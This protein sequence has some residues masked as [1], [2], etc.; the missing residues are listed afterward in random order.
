MVSGGFFME[1][2]PIAHIRSDFSEKFGIPRQSGLV[3][4]L[5]AAVVFEPPYRV[6]DALRGVEGFSHLWLIWEFSQARREGWS[7]TVRPPRLGGNKRLGV[8]ATRSPFR[9]N[10]IGLS[11]VRLLELRQDREQGPVLTVAGADLLDGTPIYDIKPYLPYA[12]CKPEAVG[13]FASQPKGTDL[14]VD[15][16]DRLLDCVPEGKRAALLAVLAQDPRPQYQDDPNRVYGM[17]FAGL[18][19][20]FQVAGERLTVTEIS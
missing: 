13:G 18:E 1:I 11:C 7:P 12:D 20:K 3:E 6:P 14:E 17:A 19:V 15:C 9:P 5:T 8:F 16:P 4:E 10:P 2:C